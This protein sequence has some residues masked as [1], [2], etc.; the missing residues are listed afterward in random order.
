MAVSTTVVNHRIN[1][2]ESLRQLYDCQPVVGHYRLPHTT[3]THV[4]YGVY[5]TLL[6]HTTVASN[7]SFVV[8]ASYNN[9]TTV[10]YNR[11]SSVVYNSNT[12]THR[13]RIQH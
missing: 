7:Y 2:H 10:V 1:V 4:V 5:E 6:L 8:Q 3:V 11:Q 9:R 12:M 13:R